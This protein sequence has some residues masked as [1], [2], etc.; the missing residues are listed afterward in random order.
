MLYLCIWNYLYPTYLFPGVKL[1][2]IWTAM[3]MWDVWARKSQKRKSCTHHIIRGS[4]SLT[5]LSFMNLLFRS[6][7]S[8][9]E[10]SSSSVGNN[11][12]YTCKSPVCIYSVVCVISGAPNIG[13]R[14]LKTRLLTEHGTRFSE[15]KAREYPCTVYTV[16]VLPYSN[17]VIVYHFI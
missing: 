12:P 4:L 7:I 10:P 15:V 17:H 13:R 9:T 16:V 5:T 11:C 2:R 8:S 3:Y 6:K 14:S 1:S